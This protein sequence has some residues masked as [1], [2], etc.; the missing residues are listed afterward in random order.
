MFIQP[1]KPSHH[2]FSCA[3]VVAVQSTAGDVKGWRVSGTGVVLELDAQLQVLKKLKLVSMLGPQMPKTVTTVL[4]R[5]IL[6]L[7]S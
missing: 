5:C 7:K 4:L 3:G 2:L 6:R 1:T